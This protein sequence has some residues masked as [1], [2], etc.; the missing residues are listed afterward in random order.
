MSWE[1]LRSGLLAFILTMILLR[2]LGPVAHRIGLVDHPGGRKT[3]HHPTPLTGGIAMF[4]AFAFSVLMLDIPLPNYRILFAGSLLLVVVGVIDDLHELSASYR[5]IAQITAGF[6]MTLGGDV[7]LVDIGHLITPDEVLSL[8]LLAVPLTVFAAVG[9]INSVNMADGLDGLA[10][11]LVLITIIAL[12]V[13]AWSGGNAQAIVVLGL[14][15]AAI[16]AFLWF[17]LRLG[18]RALVFMG[19]AGSLFLGFVLVWFLVDLSQGE[20]RLMAPVTALW[21]FALPLF[22]TISIMGRRMLLGRSPFL[23]DREHFHHILLAAGFSPK[24]V[25]ALMVSM[26]FTGACVGL[27]GHFLGVSEYWMFVGFLCLLALYFWTLMR[28]WRTRRFL[29]K[30]LA[31]SDDTAG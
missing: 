16:L 22:D 6:L 4:T 7:I 14:L 3:H 2:T 30:P 27:V 11:S 9:V 24:Q 19:D 18:E 21:L 17:N 13:I 20:Q 12:A 1:F 23:A 31:P 25:L 29:G 5:F 26:A 10:A 8:G 15:G 28:T